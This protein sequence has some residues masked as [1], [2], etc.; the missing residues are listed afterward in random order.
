MHYTI[1]S[2]NAW[3][4]TCFLTARGEWSFKRSEAKRFATLAEAQAAQTD[5]PLARLGKLGRIEKY[6]D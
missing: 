1:E 4:V 2:A 3:G 6:N 5:G